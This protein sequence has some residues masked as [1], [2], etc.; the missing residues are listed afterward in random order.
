MAATIN[1]KEENSMLNNNR[2]ERSAMTV[3]YD[4]LQKG[5]QNIKDGE[6]YSIEDA[7]EEINQI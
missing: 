3:L 1:L 4:E 7:W 6:V 2:Y 5:I